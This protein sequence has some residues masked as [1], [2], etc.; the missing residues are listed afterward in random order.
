MKEKN[1]NH[2]QESGVDSRWPFSRVGEGGQGC[3]LIWSEDRGRVYTIHRVGSKQII[4]RSLEAGNTSWALTLVRWRT[5]A[6]Q[7]Y[8]S[9]ISNH[10]LEHGVG[11][12]MVF[13][14]RIP[15]PP[16]WFAVD[17]FECRFC[18]SPEPFSHL[19]VFTC[20]SRGQGCIL[21]WSEDRERRYTIHRVG[22]K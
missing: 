6:A 12:V 16:N 5:C 8:H 2:K 10:E 13:T 3:I 1:A 14:C 21:I 9:E 4:L 20:W 11:P 17:D 22:N 7:T 15:T 18:Y 19:A